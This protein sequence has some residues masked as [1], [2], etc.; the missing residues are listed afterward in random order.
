MKCVIMWLLS[1][2]YSHSLVRLSFLHLLIAEMMLRKIF[3]PEI[4]WGRRQ[5]A[6]LILGCF[7]PTHLAT[8]ELRYDLCSVDTKLR[9]NVSM[10]IVFINNVESAF[11][12]HWYFLP[13]VHGLGREATIFYSHL[14]DLLAVQHNIQYSQILPWM[15][16]TILFFLLQSAIL[17]IWES[18]TLI[19]VEH[20]S[21]STKLCLKREPCR[22]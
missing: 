6:F 5:D 8:A 21:I 4:F 12:L 19:T 10:E 14:A 2:H 16:C 13:L 15:Q 9:R 1:L 11:L 20:P 17:A 22:Y 7:I 3:I 18:R